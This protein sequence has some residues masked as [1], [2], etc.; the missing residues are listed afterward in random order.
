MKEIHVNAYIKSDG[1]H[2]KEHYRTIDSSG[3]TIT[4]QGQSQN[5]N[6]NP[7][8]TGGISMDVDA[9]DI[10]Q[11]GVSTGGIDWG[12]IGSTIGQGALKAVDVAIKAAPIALQMY[13]A[14][15]SS[16]GRAIQYLKHQFDN[17]IKSLEETQKVMKQNLDNNLNKLSSTKNK[18]EYANLYKSF[19]KE[20]KTYKKT[21]ESITKIKHAASN[22]DYETVVNELD[23]YK[24]LQK[25]VISDSFMNN[26]VDFSKMQADKN[27]QQ[28]KHNLSGMNYAPMPSPYQNANTQPDWWSN[29]NKKDFIQDNPQLMKKALDIIINSGNKATSRNYVNDGA[30]FWNASTQDL[31]N[32]YIKN[33]G[34]TI[35]SVH[36]IPSHELK[37]KIASKL[38]CQNLSVDNTKGIVFF[39]DSDISKSIANS[40]KFKEFINTNKDTLLKGKVIKDKSINYP[41][42]DPNLWGALGKADVIKTY[43]DENGNLIST[44]IDTYEFNPNDPRILVRMGK[45]VQNGGLSIPY[46]SVI[47][48][49]IPH[50]IWS[51]WQ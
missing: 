21:S 9:E 42:S 18:E 1:T 33:N 34:I 28:Y 45:S 38:K 16:N 25:N 17:S 47:L 50:N 49:K 14:V 44:I 35:E 29:Q 26:Q 43:I 10:L 20:N 12:N 30:E 19:T 15:Q 7:V 8:L 48:I 51:Q 6:S 23:N 13:Q 31:K 39:E 46:F 11:G 27:T 40:F 5:F 36:T 32:T 3:N 4:P 24:N 37:L 41:K 22:N 2:V